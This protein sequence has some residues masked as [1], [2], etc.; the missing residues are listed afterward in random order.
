MRNKIVLI[1]PV[2]PYKGG[3]SH[4]TGLMYRE[5]EKRHDVELISY[6]MQYPK[7]LFH[8]EQRD[9][10]NDSFKI[11]GAEYMLHTANP[12][13]I[14]RT[15]RRI[16][17]QRPDIVV[18]Q[19]WHPY[20]APCY[21]LLTHFMGRQKI[22]FI[23]HNVFPHERFPMDRF[24]TKLALKRGD[25]Y[26]V[27]AREEASELEKIKKNPDYVV[28]PHPTYN[29]FR[30]EGMSK[31]Q[32]RERLH[33]EQDEHVLLFFGYVR[34]YKGL[35]YLLRAM[36]AILREDSKVRLLV[37]G[38]FGSDRDDYQALIDESGVGEH[39]NVVDSYTPDREVEKYFAA[40]DLVVLPYISA[41]QSGIVQIAYGFTKPVIVTEVGGLPDVVEDGRTGYVVQPKSPEAIAAAA[42]KFF[43]ENRAESMAENIEKEAYRFSWERMGD[44]IEGFMK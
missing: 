38:E 32:A 14:I 5:L 35:K 39:V 41:T 24:L 28:T 2:Y 31:A 27:H 20:F 43:R 16:R 42:V 23:C 25:H 1:G 30:F 37:V 11:A 22:V 33:V 10:D 6:K 7:F 8:K 29:A 17:R 21:F 13:N 34:E 15:A 26:I 19:W 9:Y 3:I 12:F 40:A 18:I 44:V 36:P 4:Y